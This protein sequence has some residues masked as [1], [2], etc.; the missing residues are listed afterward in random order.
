[1]K[2]LKKSLQA[3]FAKTIINVLALFSLKTCHRVGVLIG[4]LSAITPNR[5]RLVTE[6]NIQLCFPELNA[7]QQ[8]ELTRKSLIE[9]GKTF[10][11]AGP[12]WKWNKDKLFKL[13]KSIH[14]EKLLQKALNNKHGVI[15]ALP[16]L[17][18]W[19][20]LSLYVSANYPSTSMYQK[21]KIE[22]LESIIKHGRE[23]LGANLVPADNI[24]VRAMLTALKNN[25]FVC[26]LPDQEPNTGTGLFAPFFGLQAYS[27]TLVSRLAKK[28]QASIII[29]YTKRLASGEGYEIVF[30]ELPEMNDKLSAETLDDSIVYLNNELEKTIRNIPEQYQWSYKRFRNQ[31]MTK[32]NQRVN[33]YNA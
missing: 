18:N 24:G 5:N 25:E 14:G 1:M 33:F 11:E 3:G 4:L 20:L 8:H 28:T 30:T 21:P 17:G 22:Q 12:M 2:K 16:H 10:T 27:M 6:K 13:I 31:P 29:A 7:Q 15:L 26:I 32:D 9:T 19:E 23:R